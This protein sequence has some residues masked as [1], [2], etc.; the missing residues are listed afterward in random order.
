MTGMASYRI[1]DVT[2]R[3]VPDDIDAAWARVGELELD[4]A[5]GERVVRLRMRGE[6]A[7][8]EELGW[9]LLV[10]AGGP[11]AR[12]CAEP[13]WSARRRSRRRATGSLEA[14]RVVGMS[15]RD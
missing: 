12:A 7:A 8:G 1:D 6:L 15:T 4:A 13:I 9:A 3:D 5:G 10:P 2:L 14:R 11:A